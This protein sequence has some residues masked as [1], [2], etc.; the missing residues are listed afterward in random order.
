MTL[1]EFNRPIS[2]VKGIGEQK[3]RQLHKLSIDTV[4]DLLLWFPKRYEDRTQPRPFS[5][6]ADRGTV[7]TRATVLEHSFFPT[8]RGTVLKIT[9]SD[10]TGQADLVCFGRP[11]LAKSLPPGT[12]VY[13]AGSFSRQYHRLQSSQFDWELVSPSPPSRFRCI[14]PFYPLSQ[15]LSQAFFRR[16]LKNA[17]SAF[18]KTIDEDL[19]PQAFTCYP[20]LSVQE[21]LSEIHWP[22]SMDALQSALK[23]YKFREFFHFQQ[24]ALARSRLRNSV[25]LPPLAPDFL[26]QNR[27]LAQL[28]FSL[29]P[30]QQHV[31]E[32][33]NRDLT[34]PVP[35]ARLLQGDVGSGKT[36]VALAAA[37]TVI[38]NRKQAALLVP[39]ELLAQQHAEHAAR[40]L[41]PLGIRLALLTG[42]LGT[43]ARRPLLAGL[44]SGE[45]DLVIGTHALFSSPVEFKE[46]ALIIIDEQHKF[47]VRQRSAM[48]S[49]GFHPH[50]LLLSAT[51]I[52]RTLAQT[53][54]A[55]LSVSEIKTLPQGRIP[56]VTHLALQE[57]RNKVL[58]QLIEQIKL[59]HQAYI[60]CPRID[61]DSP[62]DE[63]ESA[64][65]FPPLPA[66]NN[67]SD[68]P[69]GVMEH[70]SR[71]S[72]G[73]LRRFHCAV[74]HSETPEAEK[75]TIM[76]RFNSGA[77]QVLFATT[78]VEVGIDNPNATVMVI[79]NADRF[80][81][82]QLHQLRGRVGRGPYPSFC[83]LIYPKT[84]SE[85]AKERLLALKST[86]DGFQ[87]AQKDLALRGPGE[88]LG[89][90]QA[91]EFPFQ[92]ADPIRDS[93][94]LS[95]VRDTLTAME[96]P[97]AGNASFSPAAALSA[98]EPPLADTSDSLLQG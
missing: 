94:L 54:Y 24:A 47:G 25:A 34:Q 53:L 10:D 57:N 73:P 60:V 42:S 16:S 33:L 55:D 21:T 27:F 66:D 45:V 35:M 82:A 61:G 2:E 31:I 83:F 30:D 28:P 56:V 7:V 58:I 14:L 79:E 64:D 88:L 20:L 77:V 96:A 41:I 39:T 51:P 90:K 15:S 80:G 6:V 5:G 26:L 85:T 91:G 40:L 3:Q 65:G 76:H 86:T 72:R 29:S 17:C 18:L 69:L 37:L 62:V 46:L 32:T 12:V 36:L 98:P 22:S 59:G 71:L 9:V 89:F 81:L 93:D 38:A 78:L 52:P 13:L 92:L 44:Q 8:R 23:S 4:G 87:I 49:K 84:L 43:A 95:A 11:F 50:L 19:P 1:F 70:F 74:L 68:A 67:D 63:S 75:E 48:L 97:A